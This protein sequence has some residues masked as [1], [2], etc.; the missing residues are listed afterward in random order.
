MD[1]LKG[2][3]LQKFENT[4]KEFMDI[5]EEEEKSFPS[6]YGSTIYRTDIIRRG[7]K[8]RNF[9]YFHTLK[10]PKGLYS[11]FVQHIQPIFE[12]RRDIKFAQM[13]SAYWAPDIREVVAA[14]LENKKNY[15]QRLQQLFKEA[16]HS[17]V[18][19]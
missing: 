15:K 17:E 14:K 7:W 19:S 16:G 13:V 1:K 10:S 4:C 2:K 8:I 12:P 9:W 11:L 3:E 18:N 6:V 5:F